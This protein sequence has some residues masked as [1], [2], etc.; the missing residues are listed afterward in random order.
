METALRIMKPRLHKNKIKAITEKIFA[1]ERELAKRSAPEED[2][3]NQWKIY[4][5]TTVKALESAFPGLPL[6]DL[7]NKE[8][9]AVNVTLTENEVVSIFASPY[10]ASTTKLLHTID[11][12]TLYN[13]LGWCAM[14]K[15]A[16]YASNS[17]RNAMQ[18][19]RTAAYGYKEAI[20]IWKTCIKL[21]KARMWEVVGRLYIKNKFTPHAKKNLKEVRAKIGYP[22]WMLKIK[23]IERLYENLGQLSPKDPFLK[24]YHK[25]D[26]HDRRRALLDLRRPFNRARE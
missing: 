16:Y 22:R 21:L 26:E 17:F 14:Q 18:V 23:H 2:R 7:L 1:F 6:L 10:F 15:W 13:Y 24:I 8:F 5:R 12:Y 20:P 19:F 11:P 3:R 9:R 25:L 4:N